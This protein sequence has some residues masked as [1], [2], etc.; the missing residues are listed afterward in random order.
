MMNHAVT[1]NFFAFQ[2]QSNWTLQAVGTCI[3]GK[4]HQK[5]VLGSHATHMDIGMT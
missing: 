3:L 5:Y 2:H 1:K 4:D